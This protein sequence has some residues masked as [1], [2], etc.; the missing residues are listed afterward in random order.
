[1]SVYLLSCIIG[2]VLSNW[3]SW[4]SCS[5]SC[6]KG[7]QERKKNILDKAVGHGKNCS[8]FQNFDHKLCYN[9]MCD[10]EFN[11]SCYNCLCFI[12][13]IIRNIIILPLCSETMT[14]ESQK[15]FSSSSLNLSAFELN[16]ANETFVNSDKNE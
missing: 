16:K 13:L 15:I 10:T 2:C 11:K 3:G 1:M 12:F 14:T 8:Q 7:F 6:G 9:D 4:G 5:N